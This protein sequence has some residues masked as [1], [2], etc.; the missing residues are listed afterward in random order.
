MNNNFLVK[1]ILAIIYMCDTVPGENYRL[2]CFTSGQ[3]W[4]F[5]VKNVHSVMF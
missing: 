5:I 4:S 2:N 3:K 1:S